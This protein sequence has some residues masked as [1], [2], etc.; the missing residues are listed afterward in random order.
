MLFSAV[1]SRRLSLWQSTVAE[2]HGAGTTA[3]DAAT[4]LALCHDKCGTLPQFSSDSALGIAAL[5]LRLAW[6]KMDGDADAA[7]SL[8]N[9]LEFV[10]ASPL[11]KKCAFNYIAHFGQPD[12]Y[13][14]GLDPVQTMPDVLTIGLL[15][16]WEQEPGSALVLQSLLAHDPNIISLLATTPII[17][18]PGMN[19]RGTSLSH[20]PH[21]WP[22]VRTIRILA[23][24]HDYY[25]GG[26]G[27]FWARTKSGNP[28]LTSACATGTGSSWAWTPATM[29]ATHLK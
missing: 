26:G 1:R 24:N 22:A 8:E 23:G 12:P 9:V 4:E 16:D 27:H 17:P 13:R 2:C 28:H 11:W 18:E 14:P 6:A 29:T 25:A 5:A 3:A 20:W 19:I 21:S 7:A 15:G 10:P